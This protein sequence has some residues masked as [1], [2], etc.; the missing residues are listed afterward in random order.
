MDC[1]FLSIATAQNCNYLQYS[2]LHYCANLAMRSRLSIATGN[3]QVAVP[4]FKIRVFV[5][6]WGQINSIIIEPKPNYGN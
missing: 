2:S 6:P 3:N 4:P 1:R 5:V